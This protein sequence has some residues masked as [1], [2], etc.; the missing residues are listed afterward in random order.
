MAFQSH[1]TGNR[2]PTKGT[3]AGIHFPIT[4]RALDRFSH[5]PPKKMKARPARIR[6][7]MQCEPGSAFCDPPQR[8]KPAWNSKADA[9]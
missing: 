3:C 6:R 2:Q 5:V 9:P 8:A 1:S 4:D 7:A